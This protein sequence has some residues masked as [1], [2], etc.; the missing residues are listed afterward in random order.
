MVQ[1]AD[2]TLKPPQARSH[3]A[4]IVRN[5]ADTVLEFAEALNQNTL[6]QSGL[7]RFEASSADEVES[8]STAQP[9]GNEAEGT[10]EAQ[11]QAQPSQ[12]YVHPEAQKPAALI[13]QQEVAQPEQP[14][15]S[16]LQLYQ[17][18]SYDPGP[19]TFT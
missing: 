17:Q 16:Q 19:G 15:M 8:S 5:V 6:H 2:A 9:A 4:V 14:S 11:P 13:Q 12:T 7:P 1:G 18:H 3:N 10:Q